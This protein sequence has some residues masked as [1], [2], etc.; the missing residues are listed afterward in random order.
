[1]KKTALITG[2]TGQDGYYLSQLLLTH[3]YRVVGLLPPQRQD[4]VIKLDDLIDKIES[5]RKQ[6]AEAAAVVAKLQHGTKL[7]V[8]K[9]TK[10]GLWH[11]ASDYGA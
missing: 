6:Q 9:C 4:S 2:I 5:R 7:K 8:Y 3:G 10:C 11:L 1:M